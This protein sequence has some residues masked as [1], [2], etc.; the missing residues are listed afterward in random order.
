MNCKSNV[1]RCTKMIAAIKDHKMQGLWQ[2]LGKTDMSKSGPAKLP[3]IK[4]HA[5][6][7]YNDE[8]EDAMEG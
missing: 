2:Q 4:D 5:R 7:D 6:G 3:Y 1:V 8:D